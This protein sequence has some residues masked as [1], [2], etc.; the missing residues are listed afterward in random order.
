MPKGWTPKHR[1]SRRDQSRWSRYTEASG[2]LNSLPWEI[3]ERVII[4]LTKRLDRLKPSEGATARAH[5]Q[6]LAAEFMESDS[7]ERNLRKLLPNSQTLLEHHRLTRASIY[8]DNIAQGK[9]IRG[10][11]IPAVLRLQRD[12]LQSYIN[13]RF[14][15]GLGKDDSLQH[16]FQRNRA[17]LYEEL[18]FYQCLCSYQPE[19]DISDAELIG[20]KGP[21]DIIP[22]IL[23]VLHPGLNL[24]SVRTYLKP[25]FKHPKL[26]PYL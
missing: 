18:S 20:S 2:D 23:S 17:R 24:G 15:D 3:L 14:P 5:I 25:S 11:H 26:P 13:R 21:G 19:L 16:W 9:I 1:P 10:G 4:A 12:N 22:M 8:L 7:I 6:A